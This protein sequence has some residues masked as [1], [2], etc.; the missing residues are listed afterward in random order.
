MNR[1]EC[2]F[3]R[4]LWIASSEDGTQLAM[5]LAQ[6]VPILI[7]NRVMQFGISAATPNFLGRF[8]IL[9][10]LNIQICG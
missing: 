3:S 6:T 2:L 9:L 8:V 7:F 1:D 4:V 10:S 5:K